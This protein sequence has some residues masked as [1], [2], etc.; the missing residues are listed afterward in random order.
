ML[1]LKAAPART[2]CVP[3][4]SRHAFRSLPPVGLTL[5]LS[6]VSSPIA[7]AMSYPKSPPFHPTTV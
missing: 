1:V 2:K 6:G 5:A 3:A 4:D 7:G